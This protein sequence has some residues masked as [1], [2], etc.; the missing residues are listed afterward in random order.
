MCWLSGV[1][2]FVEKR[3]AGFT[4]EISKD[5]CDLG[6]ISFISMG[7]SLR[8]IEDFQKGGKCVLLKGHEEGH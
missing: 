2:V 4:C 6:G 1:S 5:T 8:C 3:K 7:W